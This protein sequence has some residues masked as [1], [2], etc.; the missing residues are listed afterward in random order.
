MQFSPLR[1]F[2]LAIAVTLGFNGCTATTQIVN[3]WVSPDYTSPRFKKLLVI[4][5]SKQPSIRRT[6]EDDFV[7]KLRTAGVDAVPSYLYI[8]EDGQVGE[9]RLQEAVKRANADAVI[10]TRL[11]RVEKKT[12]VSPGFYQPAPGV[13]FGF[14]P[15]YSAAWLGYYEPPRIY[16]Y[17]VYT[18]E[19][20]LYDISKNQLVW[21]GTAQT[22]APGDIN[23]EIERYV[24]TVIDALKSKNL[25]PS[26]ELTSSR[27]NS[28]TNGTKASVIEKR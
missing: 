13:T 4:G 6:F 28:A 27:S 18:S 5:V 20:S 21:S 17:D 23:K 25:L 3:Q 1:V 24:D 16:Q 12:E 7:A 22:T 10:I 9:A 26:R 14:Y 11:V 2:V 19:T 15:G 8:P